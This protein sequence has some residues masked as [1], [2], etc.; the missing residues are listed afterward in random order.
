MDNELICY[1]HMKDI[2]ADILTRFSDMLKKRSVP[3]ASH[4]YCLKWLRYY[5]D[6][7]AKYNL[8]DKSSK[9]LPQFL[10]KLKEKKQNE[11]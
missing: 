3:I 10:L 5:L 9:S 8:P 6:Y 7:C 2:P 1:L 11:A 4:S